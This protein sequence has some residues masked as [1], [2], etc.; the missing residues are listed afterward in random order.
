MVEDTTEDIGNLVG[1][2]VEMDTGANGSA[3]GKFLR[4]KVRIP[5]NKAIM[6]G[7]YLDEEED[8]DVDGGGKKLACVEEGHP[9]CRFEY[10][11]LRDFC[12]ICGMLGHVDKGCSMMLKRGEKAQFSR[13]LKADMGRRRGGTKGRT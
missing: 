11:Y 10:E 1:T 4:I 9:F 8:N 13:W 3:M 6:R 12:Y 2:F 7:V 5:I